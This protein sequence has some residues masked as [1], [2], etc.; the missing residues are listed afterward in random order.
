MK[1]RVCKRRFG[2]L[3]FAAQMTD[4]GDLLRRSKVAEAQLVDR[5]LKTAG[6]RIGQM[7]RRRRQGRQPDFRQR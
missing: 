7:L 1:A 4:A 5:Q 3:D 2:Q 6:P